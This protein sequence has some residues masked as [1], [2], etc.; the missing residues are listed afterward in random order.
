MR[1]IRASMGLLAL[2]LLAPHFAASREGDLA[3]GC[4]CM[5]ATFENCRA[6]RR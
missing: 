1:S 5:E 4:Y 2:W 6:S 3:G